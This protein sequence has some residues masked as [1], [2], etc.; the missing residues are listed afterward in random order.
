M[1]TPAAALALIALPCVLA[2]CSAP[3]GEAGP[4]R[5]GATAETVEDAPPQAVPVD[6]ALEQAS[7]W[8]ASRQAPAG[9]W[10]DEAEGRNDVGV[11]GLALLALMRAS[12]D[13]LGGA[14]S[15]VVRDGARSLMEQQDPGNGLIGDRIGHTYLYGHA[16]ATL[17]LCELYQRSGDE[18]LRE[19]ARRAIELVLAAR[20]P[21][22]AWRYD[23]P[24]SGDN[25]TS[26]T[27]WM[28]QALVA[29]DAAGIEV[30]PAAYQG[31]LMWVDEVTDPAT[32]RVGYDSV[33]SPSSRIPRVNDDLPPE[34]GEA[35]T[36]AGLAMRVDI[37]QRTATPMADQEIATRHAEVLRRKL[38]D[39]GPWDGLGADLYYWYHGTRAMKAMGGA[40][41]D[42]W[43]RAVTSTLVETQVARGEV[44]GSWDPVDPWSPLGGRVYTTALAA[45]ALSECR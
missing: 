5:Q 14:Y 30:D 2:A 38:P 21:Y 34:M 33:G 32:G 6:G 12:P 25:D 22:G 35:M 44:A 16:I 27:S 17:A 11:S 19:P 36:A 13:G 24:P 43:K 4:P 26:V 20:N 42:A 39:P 8:L 29:A 18:S 15:D 41:W 28:T 10:S 9:L 40:W 45:L 37:G 7:A 23:Y 1:S 31:T 3:Q